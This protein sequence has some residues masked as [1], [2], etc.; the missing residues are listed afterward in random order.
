[1]GDTPRALLVGAVVIV[2]AVLLL[3]WRFGPKPSWAE[4]FLDLLERPG[5]PVI[6]NLPA[7]GLPLCGMA[8]FLVATAL[9]PPAW[10]EGAVG[11]SLVMGSVTILFGIF[12]PGFAKPPWL[13]AQQRPD[14]LADLYGR[15]DWQQTNAATG[16]AFGLCAIVGLA[17]LALVR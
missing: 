7:L 1:M 3:R 12:S 13:R 11:G 10:F 6:A 2:V 8:L 15:Q 4:R 9:V 17:V 14:H 5:Q 16:L